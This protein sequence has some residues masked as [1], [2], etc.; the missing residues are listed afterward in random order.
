[1]AAAFLD[2]SILAHGHCRVHPTACGGERK[3]IAFLTAPRGIDRQRYEI[4]LRYGEAWGRA[5]SARQKAQVLRRNR[6]KQAA[7][8]SVKRLE[9][10]A[11]RQRTARA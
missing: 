10:E 2:C 1:M 11:R 6:L 7:G 9:L 5:S 8:E 3:L 4:W